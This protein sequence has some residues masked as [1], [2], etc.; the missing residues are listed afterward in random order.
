MYSKRII[1]VKQYK[2]T[3]SFYSLFFVHTLFQSNY[4]A[5]YYV[6]PFSVIC[7]LFL[8]CNN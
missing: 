8:I 7:Y 2:L 5:I 3:N 4:F 6:S 1:A